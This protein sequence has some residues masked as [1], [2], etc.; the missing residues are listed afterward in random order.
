VFDLLN[1]VKAKARLQKAT[2]QWD[3]AIT[4]VNSYFDKTA[5]PAWADA[6]APIMKGV[7][8]DAAGHWTT[9]TGVQ[10]GTAFNVHNLEAENWFNTAALQFATPINQTSKD[11]IAGLLQQGEMEGWTISKMQSTMTDLFTQWTNGTGDAATFAGER[12]PPYRTE[13]IART[14]SMQSYNAGSSELYK[15]AGVEQQEW[16]ATND[17]RTRESHA[18]ANGQVVDMDTPFDVGGSQLL[19][20]G[21]DSLGADAGEIVNC[22]CTTVPIIPEGGLNT[23][24]ESDYAEPEEAV[25]SPI[26]AKTP[27]EWTSIADAKAWMKE[28]HP[29][30]E[31]HW[32]N[33]ANLDM[34]R[35][36][37]EQFEL[38]SNKYP[39]VTADMD[40]FRTISRRLA[41]Q[42]Y[43]GMSSGAAAYYDPNYSKHG[44]GLYIIDDQLRSEQYQT[45][46]YGG[47]LVQDTTKSEGLVTHEFG[48]GLHFY[49][50]DQSGQYFE[51]GYAADGFG[52]VSQT[53]RAWGLNTILSDPTQ[54]SKYGMSNQFENFAETFEAYEMIPES[55]WSN[56]TQQF[57][58][59]MELIS[60][61]DDWNTA[62]RA[63]ARL[64]AAEQQAIIDRIDIDRAAV[65]L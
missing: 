51:D 26:N 57:A 25:T 9:E 4:D 35:R 39:E 17:N 31:F 30:L 54:L 5:N 10:A 37:I 6:F 22:R 7:V 14:V 1:V 34:T 32:S 55:Q 50:M 53:A 36:S 33:N 19:F 56:H 61:P 40:T 29:G 21:D 24:D 8:E 42:D 46:G 64:P 60:D 43:P 59:L 58:N 49:L 62:A 16:V 38:L 11:E 28:A 2:I 18:A 15:Q 45:P 20:P 3:S 13:M 23:G 27:D 41:E 65:G 63:I 52:S 47:W 44:R 12:L 48:H